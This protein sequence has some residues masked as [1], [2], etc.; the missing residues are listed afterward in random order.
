MHEEEAKITVSGAVHLSFPRGLITSKDSLYAALKEQ[1][2]SKE[3]YRLTVTY[4]DNSVPWS[5]AVL[6]AG[7][8]NV[9]IQQKAPRG[10]S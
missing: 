4:G 7:S 3:D 10:I 1:L 6:P 9:D 2:S 5:L 8:F